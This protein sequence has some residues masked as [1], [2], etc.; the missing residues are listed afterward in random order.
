MEDKPMAKTPDEKQ[1]ILDKYFKA[2]SELSHLR[3]G[4]PGYDSAVDRYN[5]Y[6]DAYV[7][8]LTGNHPHSVGKRAKFLPRTTV[9]V[10]LNSKSNAKPKAVEE[11]QPGLED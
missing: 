6:A 7:A 4:D 1:V 11:P 10:G 9:K 2:V 8:S 3:V 5:R